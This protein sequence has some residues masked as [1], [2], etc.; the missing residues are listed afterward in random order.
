[1]NELFKSGT[2]GIL[3]RV[4]EE[5]ST[6]YL[7]EVWFDYTRQTMIALGE[8][9]MIAVPNFSSRSGEVVYSILELTSVLPVHYALV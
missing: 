9:T 7:Y 2:E 5:P 3:M 1:M 6:R 8:G 4:Q